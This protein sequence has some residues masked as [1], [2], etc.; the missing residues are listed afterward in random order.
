MDNKNVIRTTFPQ[1]DMENNDREK[2]FKERKE[3]LHRSVYILEKLK[4]KK[5]GIFTNSI[6]QKSY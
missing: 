1:F 5:Y 2:G 6:T 3:Y 4:E